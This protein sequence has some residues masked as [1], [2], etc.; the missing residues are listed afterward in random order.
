MIMPS[1]GGVTCTG[2]GAWPDESFELSML[3]AATVLVLTMWAPKCCLRKAAV[4]LVD[5]GDITTDI[6]NLEQL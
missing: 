1:D 5:V 2:R 3:E 4:Y 6:A